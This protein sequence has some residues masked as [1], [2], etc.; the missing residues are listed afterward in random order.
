MRN[1]ELPETVFD[2]KWNKDYVVP[3]IDLASHRA[4]AVA[5][6]ARSVM[7]ITIMPDGTFFA[8]LKSEPYWGDRANYLATKS[9]N[10]ITRGTSVDDVVGRLVA[11]TKAQLTQEARGS[12][13]KAK[14]NRDILEVLGGLFE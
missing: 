3:M 7:T 2:E 10:T 14:K 9:S 12:E 4:V 5:Q 11:S 8:E 1:E 13:T 6:A